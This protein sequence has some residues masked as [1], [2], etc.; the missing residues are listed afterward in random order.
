VGSVGAVATTGCLGDGTGDG[1][2][3]EPGDD[4]PDES[5]SQSPEDDEVD[6]LTDNCRLESHSRQGTAQALETTVA[7][8]PADDLRA[9]CAKTAAEAALD[10]VDEQLDLDLSEPRPDWIFPGRRRADGRLD[11]EIR[12]WAEKSSEET[13]D[14]SYTL[15]PPP[16]FDYDEALEA[17]PREVTVRLQLENGENHECTHRVWLSQAVRYLD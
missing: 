13:G 3:D 4:S 1:T 14:G 5:E 16:E 10:A 2:G 8:E 17:V 6:S 11:A 7:A 15:C 12:V 9:K